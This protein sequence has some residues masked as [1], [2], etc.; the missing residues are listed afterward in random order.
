MLTRQDFNSL[1]NNIQNLYHRLSL[2]LFH[3]RQ[4]SNY[5]ASTKKPHDIH[6]LLSSQINQLI[7]NSATKTSESKTPKE[8]IKH[9]DYS[10]STEIYTQGKHYKFKTKTSD[11][12]PAIKEQLTQHT[13][14][15][16]HAAI[17][18]ARQGKKTEAKLYVDLANNAL[19]EVAHYMSE[20]E[21]LKF[22]ATID[23]ELS[24]IK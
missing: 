2:Y 15:H 17:R 10:A 7:K 1:I 9:H 3:I 4:Q 22:T 20:D 14:Q 5:A 11:V 24:K 23:L 19:K 6:K 16:I 18:N 8:N 12:N 13:R 21:Y